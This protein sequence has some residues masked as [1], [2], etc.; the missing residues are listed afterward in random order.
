MARPSARKLELLRKLMR[1]KGLG[2]RPTVAIPR[3]S[4]G[5]D[6]PLSF[7]QRRL[8]FLDRLEPETSLYNDELVLRIEGRG[9]DPDRLDRSLQEVVRRHEILR[10]TFHEVAGE[11]IQ[12]VHPE[13][14][15]PLPRLD[16]RDRPAAA[17]AE[18]CARILL[19]LVRAPFHLDRLPLVRTV[20][21]RLADEAWE[22]GLAMHHIVSDGVSYG[23]VYREL[24]ALYA[25]AA[26]GED[27]PLPPLPIQYADY[28]AWERATITEEAIRAKLP[29][30]RGHLAGGPD[31]VR[32]PF[33][34]PRAGHRTHRGAFHRFRIPDPLHAALAA[35]CRREEVT[36]NWVLLAGWFA[37]LH[38]FT[39]QT[40][41]RVGVSSSARTHTALEGLVG[42][43]VRTL[44]VRGDLSGDPPFAMLVRRTRERALE[45]SRYEDVPFDR[46]VRELRPPGRAGDAPIVQ[47][48]FGH[49]RDV[50]AP[51]PLP[52]LRTSYEI[53]DPGNA[54]FDLCLILDETE[55][56]IECYFEYDVDLLAAATVT[57]M[58]ERYA[59]LLGLVLDHPQT[60]LGLLRE[61]LAP[62]REVRAGESAAPGPR[63]R[64]VR[65][66]SLEG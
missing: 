45:A 42:F 66:R 52:G 10:T 59:D 44:L 8:W 55:R 20:L 41:L 18:E 36:S 48:W 29:F 35:F 26:A 49:M 33:A 39:G 60:R 13:L 23:I 40:D 5:G 50:I 12:R 56:G 1:E 46:V 34:K 15:L 54:R 4:G 28:A 25:A 14:Q 37:T 38:L 32:L 30:W 27:S 53:V 64:R 57:S 62:P 2:G 58:A 9:F 16:L 51:M 21:L 19:D 3:R 24:G 61:T 6:A 65:R 11:P 47:V 63:P 22:L 43:F 17:A 7:D 31:L